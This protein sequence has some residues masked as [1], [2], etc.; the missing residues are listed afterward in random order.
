MQITEFFNYRQ[1][2]LIVRILHLL[3][4]AERNKKDS[5][6]TNSLEGVPERITFYNEENGFLIGKLKG[7]DKAG[8]GT[9]K[10]LQPH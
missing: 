4:D 3:K 7:N 6:S 1:K 2:L 8:S 9:G 10:R 5:F